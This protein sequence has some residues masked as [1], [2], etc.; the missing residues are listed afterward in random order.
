[1]IEV[2][3]VAPEHFADEISDLLLELGALS[4]SLLDA[5]VDTPAEVPVFGEPG[6]FS[7]DETDI[8][9]KTWNKNNL[10]ALLEDGA[11][12]DGLIKN[13]KK[14]MMWI[15]ITKFNQFPTLIGCL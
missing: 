12:V 8:S 1:M 4:V 2:V 6:S 13:L 5:D 7:D 15:L 10:V 11:D 3:I 9:I 14:N